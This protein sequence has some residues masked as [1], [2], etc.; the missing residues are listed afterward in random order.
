MSLIDINGVHFVSGS[1]KVLEYPEAI[2]VVGKHY[3]T[4]LMRTIKSKIILRVKLITAEEMEASERLC[5]LTHG[6]VSAISWADIR[7]NQNKFLESVKTRELTKTE[8]AEYIAS[9]ETSV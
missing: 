2:S 7:A 4:G 9:F 5:E 8:F 6:L 1:L 3:G